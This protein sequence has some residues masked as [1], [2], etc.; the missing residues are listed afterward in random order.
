[1]RS[2]TEP[3]VLVID[4]NSAYAETLAAIL[5]MSGFQATAVNSGK[6]GLE[7]AR[8]NTFDHLVTDVMMEAMNG[9]EA[10]IAIR[11]I[12]PNCHILL[13]SGH[14]DS[15]QLLASAIAQGHHFEILAKPFHPTVLLEQM[16][17]QSPPTNQ[18]AAPQS[19]TP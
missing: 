19:E 2:E 13:I 8:A 3:R 16:R 6:Q 17:A 10:A 12:L 15:A 14:N 4:D 9:I 11:E 7:I 5:N 1:M 18:R